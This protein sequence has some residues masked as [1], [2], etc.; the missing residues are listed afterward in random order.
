MSTTV[1]DLLQ[2]VGLTELTD[3]EVRLYLRFC[4]DGKIAGGFLSSSISPLGW[5]RGIG[6]R[7]FVWFFR[8]RSAVADQSIQFSETVGRVSYEASP[9]DNEGEADMRTQ[10]VVGD[11]NVSIMTELK[12]HPTF[13]GRDTLISLLK[14]ELIA[15]RHVQIVGASGTGKS[16]LLVSP[17]VAEAFYKNSADGMVHDAFFFGEESE[18]VLRTSEAEALPRL[19]RLNYG[20]WIV[21]VAGVLQPSDPE[22]VLQ[23]TR[24]RYAPLIEWIGAACL[25]D[26]Q[27]SRKQTFGRFT[28]FSTEWNEW[29]RMIDGAALGAEIKNEKAP[30]A[31]DLEMYRLRTERLKVMVEAIKALKEIGVEI[32]PRIGEK[33]NELLMSLVEEEARHSG[34]SI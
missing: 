16:M 30:L 4:E 34:A 29:L 25:V 8:W 2:M 18:S 15:D 11:A 31:P 14:D 7:F 6:H 3:D 20:R 1:L 19:N 22:R 17:L 32:D 28:R 12:N 24:F 26:A 10:M 33:V 23:A 27:R 9:E 13:V 5:L 21:G